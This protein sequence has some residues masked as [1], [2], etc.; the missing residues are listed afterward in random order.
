MCLNPISGLYLVRVMNGSQ[1][2]RWVLPGEGRSSVGLK[3]KG[4]FYLVRVTSGSQTIGTLGLPMVSSGRWGG[5]DYY[6]RTT[7]MSKGDQSVLYLFV[8][9][10]A[11]PCVQ[12]IVNASIADKH[13]KVSWR[14]SRN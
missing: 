6:T 11:L 5:R 14:S 13:L 7:E 4:G 10:T 2:D 8:E 9:Q 1:M 3:L 12:G